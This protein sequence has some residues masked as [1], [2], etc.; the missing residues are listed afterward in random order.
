MVSMYDIGSFEPDSI[1]RR[2]A[3]LYFKLSLRLRSMLNTLAAS[4]D[5]RTEPVSM[6]SSQPAP[7]PNT[8]FM[9]RYTPAPSAPAVRA[10]PAMD[11]TVA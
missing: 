5:A 11:K 3:V 2:D 9:M 10:V 7:A 4:V 6:H 1:S 8:P